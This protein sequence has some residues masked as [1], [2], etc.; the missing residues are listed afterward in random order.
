[1]CDGLSDE[2]KPPSPKLQNHEVGPPEDVS[3]NDTLWPGCGDG[4]ENVNAAVGADPVVE[5]TTCWELRLEPCKFD[6]VSVTV[7][8]PGLPK[9]LPGFC[10]V[11]VVRSPK[12]QLQDVGLPVEVSVKNTVWPTAGEGGENVKDAVGATGFV[13][14]T[15]FMT[16]ALEPAPFEAVNVT[17]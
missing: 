1:V 14:A 5:T 11:E 9:I 3:V 7:Y 8:V 4:G 10:A 2:E 13:T 12:F 16:G 17:V 15:D 6:A